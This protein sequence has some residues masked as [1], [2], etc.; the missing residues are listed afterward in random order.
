MKIRYMFLALAMAGFADAAT[1]V[2]RLDLVLTGLWDT[3]PTAPQR[4]AVVAAFV[5]Q[6][7]DNEIVRLF[8]AAHPPAAVAVTVPPTPPNPPLTAAELRLV[9]T[10]AEKASLVVR[11]IRASV[12]NR[13][14]QNGVANAGPTAELTLR[15][16]KAA[17]RAVVATPED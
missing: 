3:N 6:T 8:G 1:P 9:L 14:E 10:P 2:Q 4:A 13:V 12:L 17:A 7:P 15:D 5:A 16:A 11:T